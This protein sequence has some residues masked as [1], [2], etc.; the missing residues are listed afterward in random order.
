MYAIRSYYADYALPN[1]ND[2]WPDFLTTTWT[3]NCASGGSIDSDEGIS[4]GTSED[5]CI[6]YRL[7]TFTYTDD[8]ENTA[9]ETTRNNFV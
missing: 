9:T 1:C 6:E 5:G 7:Y 2:E 4:D 8:C 3:D